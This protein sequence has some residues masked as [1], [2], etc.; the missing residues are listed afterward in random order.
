MFLSTSTLSY[1]YRGAKVAGVWGW[2]AL[3][4]GSARTHRRYQPA[5]RQVMRWQEAVHARTLLLVPG[6]WGPLC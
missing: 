2:A 4:G 6:R 3:P 5:S 1:G